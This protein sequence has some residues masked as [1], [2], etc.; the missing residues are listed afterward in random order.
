MTN[1]RVVAIAAMDVYAATTFVSGGEIIELAQTILRTSAE[2][3]ACVWRRIKVPNELGGPPVDAW[4]GGLPAWESGCGMRVA[5]YMTH[6]EYCCFCGH[7]L[8]P[9]PREA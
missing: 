7:P 8:S 9:E 1:D 2:A 3:T 6:Y 4:S 5:T